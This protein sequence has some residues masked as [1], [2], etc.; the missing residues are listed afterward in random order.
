[1]KDIGLKGVGWFHVTLM[2]TIMKIRVL[3]RSVLFFLP[4]DY[5]AV[6]PDEW[7]Q[8]IRRIH[9]PP[10]SGYFEIHVIPRRPWYKIPVTK[11]QNIIYYIE[12]LTGWTDMTLSSSVFHPQS[13]KQ[14]FVR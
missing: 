11:T 10:S 8:A 3:W 4:V 7:L 5:E 12:L 14:R 6:C 1:M 2:E 9:F 13:R